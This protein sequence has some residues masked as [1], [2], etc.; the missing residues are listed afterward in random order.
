LGSAINKFSRIVLG[1]P[2]IRPKVDADFSFPALDFDIIRDVKTRVF[3]KEDFQENY[4]PQF[5]KPGA[6][7]FVKEFFG[8]LQANPKNLLVLSSHAAGN[9]FKTF[10]PT[11]KNKVHYLRFVSII[12]ELPENS[13]DGIL[14]KLKIVKP[15]FVVSNQFWPHKN[16]QLVLEAIDKL[17]QQGKLNFQVVFTGKTTSTRDEAYFPSLVSF[18]NDHDL[19]EQV[20]IT[21]F[22]DREDQVI[23]H[24]ARTCCDT[25]L[26]F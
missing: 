3:W 14:D 21:G 12:P 20:V 17:R 10:Y 25:T 16:H 24:E 22:L 5:F 26:V 1:K 9:D 13:L 4:Y 8:H 7:Q 15:Y 23:D 19:K 2:L 11:I 18:I 6:F